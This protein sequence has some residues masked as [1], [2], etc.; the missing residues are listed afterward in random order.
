MWSRNIKFGSGGFVVTMH[1]GACEQEVQ[2]G[3]NLNYNMTFSISPHCYVTLC[4][5]A[6]C[7]LTMPVVKGRC[8]RD[9]LPDSL[10]ITVF[11]SVKKNFYQNKTYLQWI[12]QHIGRLKCCFWHQWLLEI[13]INGASDC[14]WEYGDTRSPSLH[15]RLFD[16]RYIWCYQNPH[17]YV[18]I[19]YPC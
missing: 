6:N 4:P 12:F 14:H 5:L 1:E 11:K 17:S 18:I 3:F 9:K 13:L 7:R 2:I 16:V 19:T 15:T 10:N 8:V